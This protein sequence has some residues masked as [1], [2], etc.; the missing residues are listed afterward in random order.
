MNYEAVAPA[1][2]YGCRLAQSGGT[3]W[4]SAEAR[5]RQDWE[6]EHPGTWERVKGAV[7]HASDKVRG[8]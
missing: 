4:S 7:H 2:Q 1:Y 8:K 5:A 6:R 3:D